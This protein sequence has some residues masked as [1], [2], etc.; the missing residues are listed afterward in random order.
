MVAREFLHGATQ[1]HLAAGGKVLLLPDLGKLPHSIV[2]QFQNEFWSPMFTQSARRR[3]ILVP[4][5]TLGLLCD[6]AHP[7]FAK[8]PT[9]FHSNWQWW[10]LVRNSRPLILDRAPVG[11]TALSSR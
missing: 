5:G 11:F 8:F 7:A 4:P 10:H 2:G 1:A 6:P 9:E 3:E